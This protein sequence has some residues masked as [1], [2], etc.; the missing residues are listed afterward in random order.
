M[1]VTVAAGAVFCYFWYTYSD[2]FTSL[3]AAAAAAAPAPSGSQL[4]MSRM[5]LLWG[6]F[7][8]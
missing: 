4:L 6:G 2:D 7:N 1:G 5:L 3:A 8:S